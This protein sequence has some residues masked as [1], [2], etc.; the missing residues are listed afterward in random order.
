ML[1]WM[2]MWPRTSASGASLVELLLAGSLCQFVFIPRDIPPHG[3][4]TKMRRNSSFL[5]RRPGRGHAKQM[6]AKAVPHTQQSTCQ[7]PRSKALASQGR[8]RVG[9]GHVGKL[10]DV[11]RRTPLILRKTTGENMLAKQIKARVSQ[12]PPPD[13]RTG[14][15][16]LLPPN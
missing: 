8:V 14:P 6:H 10:T 4:L 15:A 11:I 7:S 2:A 13:S 3:H 16:S 5:V 12:I 1:R 9:Q